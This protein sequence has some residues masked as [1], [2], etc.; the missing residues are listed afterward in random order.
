MASQQTET[1]G[2]SNSRSSSPER[3]SSPVRRATEDSIS[4]RNSLGSY[5]KKAVVILAVWATGFYK[6]SPSWLLLAL[7]LY[8]WKERQ[9]TA[10][11]HTIAIAQQIAKDEKGAILAR[12]DDLPSWVYFPDVERAEWVNKIV[13]QLWPFI[14]EY[15][16]KLLKETVEPKVKAQLPP[17]L[18]SFM[19]SKIDMGN[20]PPR[21]GGVKVYTSQVKRDEIVLDLE[22]NY[23]SDCKLVVQV[24]GVNFGVKDLTLRGTLRLV[25]RPLLSKV[26]LIGGM[27][28]FFLNNPELDFNLTNLANALDLP[29]LNDILRS[30]IEEQIAGFMVLPNRIPVQI[31]EEVDIRKLRYPLP[32][33][34]LLVHVIEA[35]DLESA[36]PQLVGKGSSDPYAIATVGIQSFQTAVI[37]K[38]L[39]PVWN[40]CFEYVIDEREGQVLKVEVKDKDKGSKDDKLGST[41]MD[42]SVI[43]QKGSVEEWLPLEKVDKGSIHLLTRWL[44]LSS[45]P[46]EFDK[47][48][49]STQD[50]ELI[51]T[52]LLIV[53]LECA[54]DLPRGQKSL[55][56]PSPFALLTVGHSTQESGIR[57]ATTEPKW[58]EN[59]RFFV[60]NPN[61]QAL[62]IEVR[63]S[64]TKMDLG[65]TRILLRTLMMTREMMIDRKFHL[66]SSETGCA[67]FMTLILRFVMILN[68][69]PS[70]PLDHR[71]LG[72]TVDREH[73]RRAAPSAKETAAASETAGLE[74]STS[75]WEVIDAR[76]MLA[77]GK[78][79]QPAVSCDVRL[80]KSIL[81]SSSEAKKDDCGEFGL[82]C[83][84]LTLR[85]SAARQQLVVVLHKVINLKPAEGDRGGLADPYVTLCLLPARDARNKRRTHVV[86]R[87][88]NPVFD[89]KFDYA[90]GVGEVRERRLEVRVKQEG[91]GVFSSTHRLLGSALLDLAALDTSRSLTLWLDLAPPDA[92]RATAVKYDE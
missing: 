22:I 41:S 14:G 13:Y 33:G 27:S 15:V 1:P 58:D 68:L 64:K 10:K 29:G 59:F 60:A 81:S 17:G 46:K 82:G 74:P 65:G 56:E 85:Y 49:A 4:F 77:G 89:A 3:S 11:R 21:I 20:I 28:V 24:K 7:V 63:D 80:R 42:I 53:H 8:V 88:L 47:V 90:V 34:V 5:F 40:Q 16:R 37:D 75:T 71:F 79:I 2:T 6:I 12:V 9:Q 39:N 26:P 61:H 50:E 69:T 87:E 57:A 44:Y 19:F 84:Q 30:I 48:Q 36:D 52:A 38:N 55:Q 25:L 86:R 32:Q 67:V 45:D 18:G 92:V 73:S 62:D 83:V 31:A 72:T 66:K 76:E 43:C 70:A 78:E 54:V 35:Q 23:A 91:G 51:N